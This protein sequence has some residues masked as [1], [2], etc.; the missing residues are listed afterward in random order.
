MFTL[1]S[2]LQR[3]NGGLRGTTKPKLQCS[4]PEVLR[5]SVPDKF[6]TNGLVGPCFRQLAY[7]RIRPSLAMHFPGRP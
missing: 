3:L 6:Q 7:F 5:Q 2:L 1:D 4:D